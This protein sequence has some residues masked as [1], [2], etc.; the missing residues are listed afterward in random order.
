M[1]DGSTDIV[2]DGDACKPK[3]TDV[4]LPPFGATRD[5]KKCSVMDGPENRGDICS[6]SRSVR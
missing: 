2:S 4:I 5:V 1:V 3:S 6:F